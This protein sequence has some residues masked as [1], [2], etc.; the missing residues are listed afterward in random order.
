MD[1]DGR[2]T[3][4]MNRQFQE[5]IG[6]TDIWKVNFSYIKDGVESPLSLPD[7]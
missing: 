7:G 5:T 1:P 6:N 3:L 2:D 4:R